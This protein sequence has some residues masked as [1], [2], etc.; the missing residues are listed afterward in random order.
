MYKPKRHERRLSESG[1][2]F[3]VARF[4]INLR[5]YFR[6]KMIHGVGMLSHEIGS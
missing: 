2:R 1:L 4:Q 6:T 3:V 5:K